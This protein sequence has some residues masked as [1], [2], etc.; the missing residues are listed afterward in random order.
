MLDLTFVSLLVCWSTVVGL[1]VLRRLGPPPPHFADALGLAIPLGL[2]ALSLSALG[3]GQFGWLGRPGLLAVLLLGVLASIRPAAIVRLL[4]RRGAPSDGSPPPSPRDRERGE[5]REERALAEPPSLPPAASSDE[6]STPRSSLR[7]AF[8]A[9]LAAILL[10]SLLTAMAPPTDGDALCYHLQVPKLFLWSGSAGFDPDLHETV[11]P[12]VTELLYGV[13]LAFRGPVSCRLIQWALGVVFALNV[14][15]L[16]RPMLGRR[17]RWAATIALGVPAVSN[18]MGAPLNDVALAAFS[19]AALVAW[20]RWLDRPS[21]PASALVGILAG[22]AMGVKYPALVWAGVIGLG[23][24]L[25]GGSTR[26]GWGAAIRGSAAFGAVALLV[27]GCWYLRASLFTGNPVHPFF[28]ETFGSGLDVVLTPDKRPM[29]PTPWNVL[30]AIGPMTLDPGRFDSFA[31]QFG[32]AFLLF[33]PALLLRWPP[34]RLA[35]IVAV[36]YAFLSLCLT[37]RQSMRFVLP[38]VGPMAVAVAW[39]AADW[40]DRRGIA[41]RLLLAGVVLMLTFEAA[42]A[43]SRARHGLPAA[44]GLESAEDYLARRE[45]TYRV[46]RW[47]DAHLPD[48]ARIVGQDHRGFY[49]PRPYTM[50]KAHRRRTGLGTRGESPARIVQHFLDRGFTHLLLCPPDPPDAV[51]FDPEL[52]RLLAPWLDARVPLYAESITDPDGVTRQYAL[53][54]LRDHD[55]IALADDGETPR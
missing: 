4:P 6:R 49:L 50:E 12:L 10:G 43:V 19:S 52:G 45:P 11:Y 31:H 34:A 28:R 14:A 5:G 18:G 1:A 24:V 2:G 25:A 46:G 27:G 9:A 26:I 47:I 7:L 55:P 20:C 37:Q 30:T 21:I 33:L 36:G 38:A 51:E 15:A 13:A 3:L 53:Y 8:D 35:A 40:H 42:I 17:S 32:P 22:L 44:I 23:M 39:L 54:D 16:A 29:A 48:S 41:P